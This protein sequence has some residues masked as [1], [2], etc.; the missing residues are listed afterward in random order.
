VTRRHTRDINAHAIEYSATVRRGPHPGLQ[1]RVGA[2][3]GYK[4][5]CKIQVAEPACHL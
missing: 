4:P 2:S 3:D 1:S 5:P